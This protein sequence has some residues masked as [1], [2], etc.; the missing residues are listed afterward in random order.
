MDVF[1]KLV[2]GWFANYRH[3]TAAGCYCKKSCSGEQMRFRFIVM[4]IFHHWF[5]VK[6]SGSLSKFYLMGMIT[7]HPMRSKIPMNPNQFKSLISHVVH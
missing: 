3:K 5:Q 1:I 7:F 2:Q 6:L 4:R